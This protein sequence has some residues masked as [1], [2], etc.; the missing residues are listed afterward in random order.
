VRF[1]LKNSFS[2]ATDCHQQSHKN[3]D[4]G[5]DTILT[6]GIPLSPIL[7]NMNA[8]KPIAWPERIVAEV[9][10]SD[11][12]AQAMAKGLSVEQINWRPSS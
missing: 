6:I 11:R 2:T 4:K 1:L 12:R 8:D 3:T 7:S 5:L 10:E 9:D